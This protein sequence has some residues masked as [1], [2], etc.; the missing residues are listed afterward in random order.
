[1]QRE[2]NFMD[3]GIKFCVGLFILTVFLG[4]HTTVEGADWQLFY[5]S[6]ELGRQMFFDK[7]SIVRPELKVVHSIQKVV[8]KISRKKEYTRYT[9]EVELNCKK[10]TY[11]ILS[12]TE[13]DEKGNKI[14][15]PAPEEGKVVKP[16]GIYDNAVIG[17]LYENIC[18]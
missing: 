7:E 10:R 11:Q 14:D 6:E 1:M 8:Q 18:P 12:M 17:A 16:S 13:Y 3:R 15:A 9:M 4:A 5:Q 2:V